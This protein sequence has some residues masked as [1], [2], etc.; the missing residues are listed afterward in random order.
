MKRTIAAFL[1]LSLCLFPA[2]VI[3][4]QNE[5]STG[6]SV[7]SPA[8]PSQSLT[9]STTALPLTIPAGANQALIFFNTNNVRMAVD[10]SIPTTDVGAIMVAGQTIRVCALSMNRVRLI[11]D[12]ASDAEVYIIY[13]GPPS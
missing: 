5:C 10:G 4:Q 11:R 1:V 6:P 13:S 9:V 3:A 12:D 7:P 2:P 8:Y